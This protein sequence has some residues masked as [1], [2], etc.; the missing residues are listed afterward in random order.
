MPN[1]LVKG[2]YRSCK[3]VEETASPARRKPQPVPVLR[4]EVVG[5]KFAEFPGLPPEI[6]NHITGSLPDFLRSLLG[7]LQEAFRGGIEDN[8][9][10]VITILVPDAMR[11]FGAALIGM[12]LTHVRGFLGT[13]IACTEEAGDKRCDE[14]LEYQRDQH[15]TVNTKLGTVHY[16]RSYYHGA[17]GH[18]VWPLDVL[19]GVDE[20]RMLPELQEE[21]G[22]L[23][24]QMPYEHALQTMVRWTGIKL[25]KHTVEDVTQALANEKRVEQE[26]ERIRAFEGPLSLPQGEAPPGKVGFVGVDG[27]FCKIRGEQEE[28][29]FKLAVLGSF[30]P[31]GDRTPKDIHRQPAPL[32]TESTAAPGIPV[33]LTPATPAERHFAP[34]PKVIG[35]RYLG[36]FEEAETFVQ[37]LTVEFHKAGLHRLDTVTSCTDGATWI[38]DRLP[39]L[40]N[41]HQ[42]WFHIL[43]WYHTEER[44]GNASKAIF[45]D[46]SADRVTWLEKMCRWLLT[47]KLPQFFSA[48]THQIKVATE[49]HR[50]DVA[51]A[52]TGHYNYFHERRRLLRYK[53]ALER[54]FIIGS[55]ILEGGIRFVGKD[56]LYRT[57]MTWSV[58][59]AEEVLVLRCVWASGCWSEFQTQRKRQRIANWHRK[60]T[61]WASLQARAA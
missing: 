59:G 31:T 52:L 21:V 26:A 41:K 4:E 13:Y 32:A 53:E 37:R 9:D 6:F 34:A 27:G 43:D 58:I 25:S 1:I 33:E 12:L 10:Q 24:S 11:S 22:L 38:I 39:S 45:G 30:N 28:K 14:R 15:T 36:R 46:D 50:A 61:A 2:R 20:R 56:R 49:A 48:L 42:E 40:A 60:K 29:E 3:P 19:L 23:S 54:G 7:P 8:L 44:L 51:E 17:C 47:D 5:V 18:S 35:K 57:G 55:G 16:T